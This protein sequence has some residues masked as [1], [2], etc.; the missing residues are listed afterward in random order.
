[1]SDC[2][3]CKIANKEIP[4]DIVFE[5]E[6]V[7]AFHDVN[8]KAPTHVLIIPKKH[9]RS[10]NELNTEN[11]EDIAQVMLAAKEVA[12]L[13]GVDKSGYRAIFNTNQHAGQ[14]IDHVHLHILGGQEL[15]PM[16]AN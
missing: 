6:F 4:T 7:L 11:K 2:L 10:L 9:I 3:F 13:E 5:N 14:T 1:M 12:K 15:G 16:V 8:K